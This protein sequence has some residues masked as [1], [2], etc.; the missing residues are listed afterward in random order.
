MVLI[1]QMRMYPPGSDKPYDGTKLLKFM[2]TDLD[3]IVKF[4]PDKKVFL[5]NR[6]G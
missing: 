2:D 3:Y 5:K 1:F 4:L 6:L